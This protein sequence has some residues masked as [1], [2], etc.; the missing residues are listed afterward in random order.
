M[1]TYEGKHSGP[2]SMPINF[3][4]LSPNKDPEY[5]KVRTVP[6][7]T[8]NPKTE[9]K[10]HEIKHLVKKT[11]SVLREA[12]QVMDKIKHEVREQR[13]EKA[14]KLITKKVMDR[15]MNPVTFIK[16][17]EKD[18]LPKKKIRKTIAPKN[19][20]LVRKTS[21]VQIGSMKFRK[22]RP[23]FDELISFEDQKVS[24]DIC[25]K[26]KAKT[27]AKYYRVTIPA[28]HKLRI[29][30]CNKKTTSNVSVAVMVGDI[31][32]PVKIYH[33]KRMK[34]VVGEYVPTTQ[35]EESVVVRVGST[36]P[37]AYAYVKIDVLSLVKNISRSK[38]D[39]ISREGK[40][41]FGGFWGNKW[42]K[43]TIANKQG[44]CQRC[45]DTNKDKPMCKQCNELK[46]MCS[47][48]NG[49]KDGKCAQCVLVNNQMINKQQN[50][51]S[52]TKINIKQ[53]N[54]VDLSKN[55]NGSSNEHLASS[56]KPT[57]VGNSNIRP[58][59][60]S[61]AIKEQKTNKS[62]ISSVLDRFGAKGIMIS[63]LVVAVCGLLLIF[64]M[65][66]AKFAKRKST[67]Y[68]PF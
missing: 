37:K 16:Q 35:G 62:K 57:K 29:N 45:N 25:T 27:R 14:A 63:L 58:A 6:T 59:T 68:N 54:Q 47:K 66:I 20:R 46:Q 55:A 39:Q 36:N 32:K 48:C 40:F 15:A 10:K 28:G 53:R 33:C 44:I 2:L 13:A 61:S 65:I 18:V 41:R 12:H 19:V 9:V 8:V 4:N 52:Q 38:K 26:H 3:V 49:R 7:R 56:V 60:V 43:L 30:T 50:P 24:T 23:H 1:G 42:S 21:T 17:E 34:G 67:E 64:G 31:C 51:V 22:S 11:N 5:I